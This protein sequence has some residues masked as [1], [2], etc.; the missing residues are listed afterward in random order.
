VV[1]AAAADGH[2]RQAA[3]T[4]APELVGMH[5]DVDATHATL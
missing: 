2:R 1:G 5:R 3:G 4:A